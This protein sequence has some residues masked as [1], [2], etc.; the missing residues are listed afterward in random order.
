METF[1]SRPDLSASRDF[2]K[3]FDD[4]YLEQKVTNHKLHI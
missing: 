4:E 2:I 3:K 1:V